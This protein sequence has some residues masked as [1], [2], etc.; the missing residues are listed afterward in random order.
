MPTSK[1]MFVH[2]NGSHYSLYSAPL[3][4]IFFLT[5]T[6]EKYVYF[7]FLLQVKDLSFFPRHGD[8][9][10]FLW[11][12]RIV[13]RSNK[14]GNQSLPTEFKRGAKENWPYHENITEPY[15]GSV[16]FIVTQPN[17]PFPSP[18][19][20]NKDD[21]FSCFSLLPISQT[22]PLRAVLSRLIVSLKKQHSLD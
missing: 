14:G 12:D 4:T 18:Q 2:V 22:L 13:F 10:I 3:F 11:G 8:G 21:H 17:S 6:W 5:N 19:A 20:I 15:R 7:N 16:N 1:T 9:G